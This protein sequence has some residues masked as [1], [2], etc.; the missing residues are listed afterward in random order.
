VNE[1]RSTRYHRRRRRADAAGTAMV[2]VFLLVLSASG[3]A[4]LFRTAAE[5]M[6]SWLPA[7]LEPAVSV[8]LFATGLA[9][10]IHV[11]ELPFAWY[12]GYW[13]ERRYGLSTQILPH[14]LAD[15]VKAAVASC[16]VMVGGVSAVYLAIRWTPQAW[17]LLAA[18]L[19]VVAM[20]G[21]ARLAPVV[22][23]PIFYRV[24]PLSRP[25]LS[26]RLLQLAER[27]GTPVI[28]AYEWAVSGHTR[29]A[30]AAL[31]GIG[32]SRRILVSDTMLDAY[33]EDEIEVILAHELSHHVHHDLWRGMAVQAATIVAGFY[34]ASRVLEAAVPW[35]GLRG[36]AD[37]AGTPLLLLV[38]GVFSF[39]MLPLGNA[40]SRAQERRADRFA[41]QLTRNPAAF[42]SAMRRLSQQNLAEERP[43]RLARWLFYSHPPMPERIA[44][45]Q[46]W[47]DV[48]SPL[49]A[50][51]ILPAKE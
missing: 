1:D 5:W 6:A 37:V 48:A 11:L 36:P 46:A 39:V 20:I 9:A 31:A 17:W 12:Q 33:S 2:G 18:A 42:V 45:A 49:H 21:L 50:H 4:R 30:N 28:G 19:F 44:A 27:A 7:A 43:S 24:R 14:W 34:V 23:L 13:L 16:A 3:A 29:K 22:L 25:A 10:T 35:L 15:Y 40:V 47:A 8:A 38:A 32:R 41:L 26:D 51:G